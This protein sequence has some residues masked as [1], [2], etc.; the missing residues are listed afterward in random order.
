MWT[1]KYTDNSNSAD[2]FEEKF[3][4]IEKYVV[5]NLIFI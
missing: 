5:T 1:C 4:K 2:K 3:S